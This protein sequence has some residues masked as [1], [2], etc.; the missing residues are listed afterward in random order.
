M[1]LTNPIINIDPETAQGFPAA[2]GCAIQECLMEIIGPEIARKEILTISPPPKPEMGDFAFSCFSVAQRINLPPNTV[3]EMLKE[4][5]ETNQ[6]AIMLGGIEKIEVSGPYVNIFLKRFKTCRMTVESILREKTDYGKNKHFGGKTVMVEYLAPNT[7]KPLHI[8]HL[9]NGT[10]GT[11]VAN[12]IEASGARVIRANNIN[13]RG[14]HI[15][16]SMIAYKLWGN[17]ETPTSTK[18]KGDHFVGRYYVKFHQEVARLFKEWLAE[19][20][21]SLNG[22][23]AHEKEKIKEEFQKQCPLVQRSYEMLNQWEAGDS[24]IVVLWKTMNQ[25]V[26]EGFDTTNNRMG[27]AFEKVYYESDTYKLG[28]KIILNQLGAGIGQRAED[29]SVVI[30]L[31]DA[32]LGNRPISLIR[33]DGTSLYITQ[34]IGLAVTRFTEISNLNNIIYVV[35]KEQEFHFK[36]LFEILKRYGYPWHSQLHHLSYGMVNLPHGR[37]KSREGTVVD[38]DE[39]VDQLRDL[40]AE[41]IRKSEPK[42]P[43]EKIS[44]RAEAVAVGALKY[45]LVS[46]SPHRDIM[47][48]PQKSVSL[49]GKTG[50][51]IQYACV[52]IFAIKEKAFA[53]ST[54]IDNAGI[55][56]DIEFDLVKVLGLY[57]EAVRRAAINYDPALL[58]DMLYDI[59]RVFSS[60]YV[61]CPVVHDDAVNQ[62]RLDLCEATEQVLKNGLQL[63]GIPIPDKM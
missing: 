53:I 44:R 25:W 5:L 55:I 26:Y 17:G 43:A 4:G 16:Q 63:L 21:I 49:E 12:L 33:K 3:A 37:M 39:L 35:G 23:D 40:V 6:I 51:Y 45:M 38:A 22:V 27:F 62:F 1:N 57:P 30:D 15:V 58:A 11:T 47:F 42:T 41:I 34:D 54:R 50:P 56:S 8:G 29:N 2:L 31:S 18:E 19:K 14:I 46:A 61:V 32:K 59:A 60:F 24:E 7:N 10:I 9:R 52:R 28:R 20:S 48:D 13:D 36:C